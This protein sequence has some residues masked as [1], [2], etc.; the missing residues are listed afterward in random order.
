VIAVSVCFLA[1][2]TNTELLKYFIGSEYW[3]GLNVVPVLLLGY[4]CLGVYMN[5]S[6]WYKLS[7]QTRFGFYIS[8]LGAVSTILLNLWLI[9]RYSYMGSAWATLAAYGFMMVLSYVL[10]QR[11]YPIPYELKKNL[12]YI[13]ISI[14]LAFLSFVVLNSNVWAGN[15]LLLLYLTFVYAGERKNLKKFLNNKESA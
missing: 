15:L 13:G 12:Q 7:D 4:V 14:I 2:V 5:L 1:I 6:I 3:E 11:N 10:G 9:P 8:G